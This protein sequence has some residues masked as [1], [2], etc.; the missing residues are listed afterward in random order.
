[1]KKEYGG[2]I[3]VYRLS[4]VTTN[5]DTGVRTTTKDSVVVRR[6]VVLP[7]KL[8]R[9]VI[10]SISLISANKQVVQGGTYDPGTR[11]FIID[12]TDVPNWELRQDDWIIYD[13]KKYDIKV[14]EEFEQSTA[15]LITA[16]EVKLFVPE[17]DLHCCSSSYMPLTSEV[18]YQLNTYHLR[19]VEDTLGLTSEAVF[20]ETFEES[21]SANLG[22]TSEAVFGETFEESLSANLGVTDSVV[23]TSTA[24]YNESVSDTLGVTDT[25]EG[26][27]GVTYNESVTSNLALTSSAVG[28][29]A[30]FISTWNTEQSGTSNSLQITLPL[31]TS[32]TYNF[33]VLWGDGNEDTITTWNDAAT[34][35]TYNTSGT[36]T[37]SIKGTCTGWYFRRTLGGDRLKIENIVQWGDLR[38]GNLTQYFDGASNMACSATDT[39]NLSGTDNLYRCFADC[40]TFNGDL[41]SL[42]TS[43]IES[44]QAI[45]RGCTIF[46]RDISSW[47]TANVED[48]KDMF[49]EAEAFNQDIG[50]WN[51]SAVTTTDGMFQ[52]ATAFTQN[53]GG[54]NTANVTDM[55]AMFDGCELFN[56][57]ISSWNTYKVLQMNLMFRDCDLFNQDI[58]SWN[59]SNTTTFYG[60]FQ[61]AY[62]FDQDIAGW[63]ITN[64]TNMTYMF[65]NATLSTANYDSLLIGWEAQTEQANVNFH[66]GSSK[67][68][69]GTANAARAS[70]IS[71]SNWTITDGSQ[72]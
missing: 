29:G 71:T 52:D 1:M 45:F 31:D 8:T 34:T 4:D 53:V 36:Y 27:A 46:N 20:G 32:G 61:N 40:S 42:N 16:R 49:K 30:G 62:A 68:S 57:D 54:W 14:I 10:Q 24:I 51:T 63:D 41:S 55:S 58:G 43:L 56:Q 5:L 37:I 9:D 19:T 3:T 17:Q 28:F 72:V 13:G 22:L 60:M 7:N 44:M 48:M 39:L 64:V 21:L 67:Y 35:H 26:I 15:W 65:S 11:S 59:T 47:N 6:A 23:G 25:V 69:S 38:L 33:T 50:S 66:G 18:A 12:R 2:Q 70:L